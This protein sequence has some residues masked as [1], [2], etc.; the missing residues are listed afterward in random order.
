MSKPNSAT[1]VVILLNILRE[2]PAWYNDHKKALSEEL[3]SGFDGAKQAKDLETKLEKSQ[4]KFQQEQGEDRDVTD[5]RDA[6]IVEVRTL[7]RSVFSSVKRRAKKPGASKRMVSDFQIGQPSRVRTITQGQ[8]FLAKLGTKIQLHKDALAEGKDRTGSWLQSIKALEARF[9]KVSADQTR[10]SLETAQARESRNEVREQAINFVDDMYL[11]AESVLDIS[12]D[13]F[14]ELVHIF[15][16][17]NPETPARSV[18]SAPVETESSEEQ[19]TNQD[20]NPGQ[21]EQNKQ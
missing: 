17:Q 4:D 20:G 8:S 21:E 15:D 12:E 9:Q 1:P 11:A 7:Y 14:N 18:S 3:G 16:T 10:E 5:D 13:P 2:I 6:A 19:N